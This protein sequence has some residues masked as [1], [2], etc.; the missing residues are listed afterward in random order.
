MNYADMETFVCVARL[1]SFAKAAGQL[2]IT[3]SAASRRVARLEDGLQVKLLHRTTRAL[4][5]TEAGKQFLRHAQ[6][7]IEAAIEAVDAA[8]S[9]QS[10]PHGHLKVHAPMS[11]GKSHVAPLIPSFLEDYPDLTIDLSF[12]D[13]VPDLLSAGLDV[14]ITS[15]HIS[16]GSYISRKIGPQQSVI[17]ATRDYLKGHEPV[18]HPRS[19]IEHNCLFYEHPENSAHWTFSTSEDTFEVEVSGNIRA[20][21]GDVIHGLVLA[22]L[23]IARLPRFIAEPDIASG[24]L[25]HLLQDYT[26]P[27]QMLCA[28]YPDR[29][30]KSAKLSAFLDFFVPKLAMY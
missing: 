29:E 8:K 28:V 7:A 17:C 9:H 11:Y 15:R 30:L 4:S 23:G 22:D 6:C 14:A 27:E 2:N 25:I 5:L 13:Q 18:T 26:L 1:G 24:R 20:D 10:S 16:A 3:A 19:L 12:N 21:S